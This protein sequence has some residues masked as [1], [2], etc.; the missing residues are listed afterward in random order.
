MKNSL[1]VKVNIFQI[2]SHV[3][4]V[5]DVSGRSRLTFVSCAT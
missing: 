1:E 2:Q 4:D 5:S 3:C